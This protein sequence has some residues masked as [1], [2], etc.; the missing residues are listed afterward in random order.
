MEA[1]QECIRDITKGIGEEKIS[2]DKPTR[3]AHRI[4]HGPEALLHEDL[5]DFTPAAVVRPR[6]TED[7][8]TIVK[9]ANRYEIPLIPQGGRTC[10]YGAESM[11]DGI[12]VDTTSMNE[13]LEFDEEALRIGAQAGVRVVDYIDYL[14]KR[15]YMSLEFPTMNR[16]STLGSRASIS[17]YN[18]FENRWGGSRDHIRGLEVVLANGDV[19][20]VGRGSS[21]PTKSV[22]GLD[23]MSM[24]IGS[25][26]TLGIITKVTER[27]IPT[28]PAYV[29]GIRA[30]NT[31][32]DALRTYMELRSPINAGVIWRA[33]AYHKWLLSQAV[34][35]SMEV[36]WPDDV[37]MLVD[38]H[39]LGEPDVVEATKKH[40]EAICKEH[41]G[42]W[43]DDMPPTD[44]VGRM[45]E[46]M[47]KYMG[48][49]ALQSERLVTGGMGNRIVPL[50]PQISNKHLINFYKDF[51]VFLKRLEDGKSYPRLSRSLRVLSPGAPVPGEE[52]WTKVW[53]LTLANWKQFDKTTI[54]EFKSWFREYAEL[55]WRHCGSL[56]G[57]HGFVPR[58]MEI[59]FI[60]REVGETGY[61]LMKTIKRALD[62]KN[63]MNPNVK[64]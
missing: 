55:V 21:T 32:E 16:A 8:V 37:V 39:I 5:G 36:E 19:V 24:F 56:T 18:K 46:T 52:G 59:E 10:T 27:F 35:G 11:R 43:R 50:D 45:H 62:P 61:E 1:V 15:G 58:E 54:Q 48:M 29:Y 25:R 23:M 20:Q 34:K 13:I 42:F 12:V 63:I 26:G 47:E 53:S 14:A 41:N 31:I 2:V 9:H 33:K 3:I 60:K 57:T 44:F 6:T 4:T 22:V 38:Y 64:F 7:V 30:F 17:G 28:P 51:L 49:A 40:A